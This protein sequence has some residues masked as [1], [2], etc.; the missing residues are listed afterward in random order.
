[1]PTVALKFYH[2][3]TLLLY[4]HNNHYL[5]RY[6]L[7]YLRHKILDTQ[8]FHKQLLNL[9]KIVVIF[10]SINYQTN[11]KYQEVHSLAFYNDCTYT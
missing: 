2:Y 8:N 1:M 4:P 7:K 11:G 3:F 9:P 6:I 10:Y 5:L